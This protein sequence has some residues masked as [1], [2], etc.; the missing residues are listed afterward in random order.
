MTTD[1]K[2]QG[3]QDA[4]MVL[5]AIQNNVRFS[6][7]PLV[8]GG[9]PYNADHLGRAWDAVEAADTDLRWTAYGAAMAAPTPTPDWERKYR[10]PWLRR[11]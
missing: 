8:I 10:S 5:R 4:R 9:V 1:E 3:L 7:Q 11:R 6:G 2:L